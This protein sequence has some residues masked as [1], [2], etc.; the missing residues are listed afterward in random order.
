CVRANMFEGP[1]VLETGQQSASRGGLGL[2]IVRRM[3]QLHGG[4][5]RL[6]EVPAGAC[7]QFTLPL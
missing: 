6:L 4:E 1:S 2:M 3:L 5:I 7:F